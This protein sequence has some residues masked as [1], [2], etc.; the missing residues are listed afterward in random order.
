MHDRGD[1]IAAIA[2]PVGTGSIGVIRVSGN[3]SFDICGRCFDGS[4]GLADSPHG[5]FRHGRLIHPASG[6]VIDEVIA[7]V[8]RAPH[9]YTAEDTVEISCHGNPY[10]LR[11]AL[12]IIVSLGARHAE[13]GEFTLRAYLNGRI[14][15]TQAEAVNDLIRAHTGYAKAA[16]L[17]GLSGRLSGTLGEIHSSLLDLLALF[18]A[19]VDHSDLDIEFQS[20]REHIISITTIRD[21]IVKLLSTARAGK[22]LSGGVR[23]AIIGAPNTGKSSLMNLL[24]REDRVLVSEIEGTTRDTVEDELNIGGIPVRLIDTAGIRATGDSIEKKGIERSLAA[25]ENADL[26]IVVFD[27]SRPVS[28]YDR[29]IFGHVKDRDCIFVLNKSDLPGKFTPVEFKKEFGRNALAL[30]AVNGAGLRELE[31]AVREFYFSLGVNPSTDTIVANTRQEE[32]LREAAG[33][34][35]KAISAIES[36]L[37]EE[38]AASDLRK[39][40]GALEEITGKT[41]GD[42]ILDRIFSKFCI[43][44]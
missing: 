14:D 22:I 37:S 23:A 12:D 6:E 43:G 24:L 19:S 42:A 5:T 40:R 39:A 29:E 15:L 28:E 26:R 13:P 34:L 33:F 10:I 36:G 18:E 32:R 41:S 1:T 7:A 16:A 25:I 9:S 11:E 27:S 8:F 31:N 38:F 35:D 17:A 4:A 20:S 30:S 44:K 3:K 2:T 21:R